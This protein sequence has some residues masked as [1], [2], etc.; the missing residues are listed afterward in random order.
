MGA[1]AAAAAKAGVRRVLN[2]A[3][4]RGLPTSRG[5]V[6]DN[7]I[8]T[9]RAARLALD[10]ANQTMMVH[11]VEQGSSAIAL[12]HTEASDSKSVITFA[13]SSQL[14][15]VQNEVSGVVMAAYSGEDA[16]EARGPVLAPNRDNTFAR[17]AFDNSVLIVASPTGFETYDL[18]QQGPAG[19]W[20]QLDGL[21]ETASGAFTSGTVVPCL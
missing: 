4:F 10:R 17:T 6:T 12:R 21:V 9:L 8:P 14:S 7:S 5:E 18:T 15:V 19:E 13:E 2:R 3:E 20:T 16:L 11:F 1:E